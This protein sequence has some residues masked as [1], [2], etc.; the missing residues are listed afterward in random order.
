MSTEI[1]DN[2]M[3]LSLT[4]NIWDAIE[5]TYSKLHKKGYI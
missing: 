1:S 2:I 3:F 5:Q 4:K